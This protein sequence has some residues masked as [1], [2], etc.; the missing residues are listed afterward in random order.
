[1]RPAF[2]VEDLGGADPG[3]HGDAYRTP[4]VAADAGAG[5]RLAFD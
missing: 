3:E 5:V 1:V 4:W 2:V